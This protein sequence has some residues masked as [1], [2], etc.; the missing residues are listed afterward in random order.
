[1]KLLV[2]DD[3]PVI[4][5]LLEVVLA[6]RGGH[7]V[8]SVGEAAEVARLAREVMPDA[9]LLDFVM[10]QLTGLDVAGELQADAA[11]AH[12]PVIFLTGRADIADE[13]FEDLN[14]VGVIEKPFETST[15]ADRIREMVGA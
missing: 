9:V 10:P 3:D 5:Y 11:T 6:K 8:T 14:I 2:C 4:R 13:D 1:M 7:D 15:L 12:I